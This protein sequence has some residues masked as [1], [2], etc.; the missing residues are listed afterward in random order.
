MKTSDFLF[1]GAGVLAIFY[2]MKKTDASTTDLDVGTPASVASQV[3]TTISS[4]ISPTPNQNFSIPMQT[5]I[6]QG[7]KIIDTIRYNVVN[8]AASPGTSLGGTAINSGIGINAPGTNYVTPMSAKF[9][10]LASSYG[11]I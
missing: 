3:P 10:K 9:A 11:I 1:L 2:F 6:S 5:S 7:G 8:T 4:T